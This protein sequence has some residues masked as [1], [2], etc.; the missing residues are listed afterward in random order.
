[1]RK[2]LWEKMNTRPSHFGRI[3]REL[4]GRKKALSR[5][6]FRLLENDLSRR[7]KAFEPEIGPDGVETPD[8]LARRAEMIRD[9]LRL[10]DER[11]ERASLH[12]TA[13][14][15]RDEFNP[16]WGPDFPPPWEPPKEREEK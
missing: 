5:D 6:I 12:L 4:C 8:S 13:G 11:I 16:W 7:L 3:A 9:L 2:E 15:P 14:D 10:T 1:M